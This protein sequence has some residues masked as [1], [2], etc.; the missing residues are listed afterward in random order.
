MRLSYY[1]IVHRRCTFLSA[2]DL[3]GDKKQTPLEQERDQVPL[4]IGIMTYFWGR[5]S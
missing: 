2:S 1:F 4:L 5:V 3:N